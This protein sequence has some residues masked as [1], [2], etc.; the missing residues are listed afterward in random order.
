MFG[1]VVN[2]PPLDV[3]TGHPCSCRRER[4]RGVSRE[5]C[6]SAPRLCPNIQ[7]WSVLLLVSS[8]TS[9]SSLPSFSSLSCHAWCFPDESRGN[10]W[11]KA[12]PCLPWQWHL[13]ALGRDSP[14]PALLP[15][16]LREQVKVLNSCP[17]THQKELNPA[18]ERLNR[19]PL[20]HLEGGR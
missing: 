8:K 6:K 12:H 1:E 16:P 19:P 15:S 3:S 11:N 13:L 2:A 14:S 9:P 7:H 17:R 4:V 5:L 18:G 10:F 20:P